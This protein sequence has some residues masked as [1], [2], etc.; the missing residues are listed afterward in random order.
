M[1]RRPTTPGDAVADLIELQNI[2]QS[3]L[4]DAIGVSRATISRLVNGRQSLTPDLAMRLGTYFGDGPRI[5]LALQRQVDEW[6]L[7]NMDR[8]PYSFIKPLKVA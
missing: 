4:A 2:S 1:S 5:W 6:D 8:S 7:M 3:Q